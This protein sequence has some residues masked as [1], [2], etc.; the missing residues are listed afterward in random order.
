MRVIATEQMACSG[1]AAAEAVNAKAVRVVRACDRVKTATSLGAIATSIVERMTLAP[2]KT[3]RRWSGQ[4]ARQV[5]AAK[6][7]ALAGRWS[8]V[9]A[10]KDAG[11]AVRSPES[12][13]RAATTDPSAARTKRRLAWTR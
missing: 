10:T 7:W 4:V 11:S 5:L 12:G 9:G 3:P 6:F 8:D 1:T 13:E 2:G